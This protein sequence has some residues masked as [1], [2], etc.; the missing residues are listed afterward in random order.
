MKR[1]IVMRRKKKQK[2]EIGSAAF[3]TAT[4]A[5]DIAESAAKTIPIVGNTLEGTLACV[6]KIMVMADV[7]AVYSQTN[8]IKFRSQTVKVCRTECVDLARR[9]GCIHSILSKDA[10]RSTSNGISD[11][12][13][14]SFILFVRAIGCHALH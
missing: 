12:P 10:E 3:T 4:H 9:A 13:L 5:L 8:V 7:S 14:R 1:F 11:E 2:R 6:R